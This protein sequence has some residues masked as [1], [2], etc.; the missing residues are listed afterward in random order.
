[1]NS[2]GNI[3]VLIMAAGE[4]SRMKGIKQILPWKGSTLLVHTLKTLLR[5]QKEHLFM[6][7]GANS[8]LIKT[9]SE[10]ASKPVTLLKNERWQNGLGSSISFGIDYV[11]K[12]QHRFDGILIC[13]ADQPLLTSAYYTEMLALF[14]MSSVPIVATKYPN[15]SGVPAIFSRELARELIH[16]DQDYGARYLMSK[17]KDKMIVLDAGGQIVDIDTPET[18]TALY[19][20]HNKN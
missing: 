7:L 6:V 14:K 18:Y 1:M 17:Y 11:L 5:V 19:Q 8:E 13:L 15:K 10:L 4:S 3:A 2:T 12:Q 20:K 9:E 16:L